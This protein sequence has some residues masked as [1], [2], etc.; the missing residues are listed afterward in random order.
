MARHALNAAVE[1]GLDATVESQ[2]GFVLH[3]L[4]AAVAHGGASDW[5]TGVERAARLG[6]DSDT[7]ACVAGAILGGRGL[8]PPPARLAP[9]RLGH[10]WPGW[11][12]EWR[13]AEHF[14]RVVTDAQAARTH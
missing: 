1:T 2:S 7:V 13:C 10:T 11:Q 9:L 5:Q 12:R 3:T 8:L 6:D 4:G 14:G